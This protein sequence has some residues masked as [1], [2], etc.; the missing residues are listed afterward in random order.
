[1]HRILLA[2][3]LLAACGSGTTSPPDDG[4]T[5]AP[6]ATITL[7]PPAVTVPVGGTQTL[8]VT[9]QSSAG[10]TLSGRT[11]TWTSSNLTVAT[12]AAGLVTGVS[13]G[14]AT[15]TASSEGKSQTASA[16]VTAGSAGSATFSTI[17][18]GGL[19]TCA[20]TPAGKPCCW[21]ANNLSQ[22]G[23]GTIANTYSTPQAV[24]GNL[25]FTALSAGMYHTC[26][27]TAAGAAWCWGWNIKG[28]LGDGTR[29]SCHFR[30]VTC[31]PAGSPLQARCIAGAMP[32]RS[33]KAHRSIGRCR[34]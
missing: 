34:H 20:I 15:I 31:T 19:H 32:T 33:A 7:S 18:P 5:P 3:L 14:T 23:L 26:G 25:T 2:A 24:A 8:I 12:V 22:I 13:A 28:Q 27:V 16:T 1:M 29:P 17:A 6:V 30:P 21:G 9:L 4:N 10:V 11:V